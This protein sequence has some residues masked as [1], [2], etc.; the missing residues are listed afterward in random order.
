[1]CREPHIGPPRRCP[2]CT[3]IA[4]AKRKEKRANAAASLLCVDCFKPWVGETLSCPECCKKR[5]DKYGDRSTAG[6]LCHRCK[7]NPKVEGTNTCVACKKEDAER[8]ARVRQERKEQGTCIQ[9]GNKRMTPCGLYCIKCKLQSDAMRLLGSGKRWRE[10]WDIYVKQGLK[11]AYTGEAIILGGN[12]SI[13]HITPTSRGGK[14]EIQNLQWV[15]WK[16]NQ[17]KNDMTHDE[18]VSMCHR[19]SRRYEYLKPEMLCGEPAET[20]GRKIQ[21]REIPPQASQRNPPLWFL[22]D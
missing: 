8:A 11:C 17:S 5:N 18:F 21:L 19:V 16:V 9:C 20:T 3:A 15:S 14:N 10:L 22:L 13:D 1:M 12:A 2:K 4:V 7:T 6:I